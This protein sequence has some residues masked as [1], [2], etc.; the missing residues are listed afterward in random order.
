MRYIIA[1]LSIL[2]L[3]APAFANPL[4]VMSLA[5]CSITALTGSASQQ[6]LAGNVQRKYLQIFNPNASD[7]IYVNFSGGTAG[8]TA[9]S[10]GTM[11]IAALASVIF[12]GS[13]TTPML[14]NAITVNGTANDAII[15]YEGR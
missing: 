14:I 10:T 15:C 4:A 8:N 9:T 6:I 5:D 1:V 12:T 3:S 7:K 13:A 2:T 11:S